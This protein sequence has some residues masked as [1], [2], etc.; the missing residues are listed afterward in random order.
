MELVDEKIQLKHLGVVVLGLNRPGFA[1]PWQPEKH[2][3]LRFVVSGP[4]DR[5]VFGYISDI[6]TRLET[7]SDRGL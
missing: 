5:E 6:D 7:L 1:K 4:E 3:A 2:D